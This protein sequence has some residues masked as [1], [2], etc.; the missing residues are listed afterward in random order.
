VS[1]Y[2]FIG[3]FQLCSKAADRLTK[4]RVNREIESDYERAD[5]NRSTAPLGMTCYS[6]IFPAVDVLLFFIGRT[7]T[8]T[9]STLA[10]IPFTSKYFVNQCTSSVFHINLDHCTNTSNTSSHAPP[11]SDPCP[12]TE[13]LRYLSMYFGF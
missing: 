11:E 10:S 8:S 2:L 13:I 3:S 4:K 5:E 6:I 9:I 1:C 12:G 7:T